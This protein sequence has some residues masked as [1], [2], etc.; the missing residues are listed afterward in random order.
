METVSRSRRRSN[1]APSSNVTRGRVRRHARP[2]GRRRPS[3]LSSRLRSR[4][5]SRFR[6]THQ[7]ELRQVD[8]AQSRG[9]ESRPTSR[10]GPEVELCPVESHRSRQKSSTEVEAHESKR[11]SKLAVRIATR[12]AEVGQEDEPQVEVQDRVQLRDSN[13]RTTS[14]SAD[15]EAVEGLTSDEFDPT[16]A[17]D[18]VATE[19]ALEW[20]MP[21][22]GIESAQ[23]LL[24]DDSDRRG[25]RQRRSRRRPQWPGRRGFRS[26]RG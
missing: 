23:H 26:R 9:Q 24:A 10:K 22:E 14:T 21:P 20:L 8:Q 1:R 15:V 25:E 3:R 19:V 2:S 4:H 7:I 11:R 16:L 17:T 5:P 12:D 18:D 6:S 13:P